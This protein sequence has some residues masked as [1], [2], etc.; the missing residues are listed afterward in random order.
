MGPLHW[1]S[2]QNIAV[3]FDQAVSTQSL[4]SERRSDLEGLKDKLLCKGTTINDQGGAGGNRK[5]NNF[6]GPSPGKNKF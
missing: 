6:G 1:F 3:D 5:K 2:F 4:D